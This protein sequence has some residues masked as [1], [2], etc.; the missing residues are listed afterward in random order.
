MTADKYLSRLPGSSNLACKVPARECPSSDYSITGSIIVS[1]TMCQV[2]TVEAA[3][4]QHYSWLMMQA[5]AQSQVPIYC[6]DPS[7]DTST[8]RLHRRAVRGEEMLAQRTTNRRA[9]ASAGSDDRVAARR[10]HGPAPPR[11]VGPAASPHPRGS[12]RA[13]PA[14]GWAPS[15]PVCFAGV[16]APGRGTSPVAAHCARPWL[17]VRAA[18]RAIAPCPI[19]AVLSLLRETLRR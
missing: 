12:C 19:D 10:P 1:A 16:L 11:R 17:I 5:V 3:D 18:V 8:R 2:E 9:I 14:I 6:D 4:A 7:I 15:S 13:G